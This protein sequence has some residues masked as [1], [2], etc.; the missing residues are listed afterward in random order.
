MVNACSCQPIPFP[1]DS[2]KFRGST[3]FLRFI[4]ECGGPPSAV[5]VELRRQSW[6]NLL[7]KDGQNEVAPPHSIAEATGHTESLERPPVA[8]AVSPLV[9][10]AQCYGAQAD[11]LAIAL[12]DPNTYPAEAVDRSSRSLPTACESIHKTEG[13]AGLLLAACSESLLTVEA[14]TCK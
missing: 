11:S 3:A 1:C 13:R 7:R 10:P 6:A 14:A 12:P 8:E 4:E 5:A 9:P 2:V